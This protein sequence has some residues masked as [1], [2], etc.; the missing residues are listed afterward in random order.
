MSNS[1]ER[2][3]KDWHRIKPHVNIRAHDAV[4][5]YAAPLKAN[6]QARKSPFHLGHGENTRR[7]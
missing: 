2:T 7:A 4:H 3:E 6:E 1:E 5:L